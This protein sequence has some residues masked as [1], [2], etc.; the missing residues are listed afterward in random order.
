[1][2]RLGA[3]YRSFR[4]SPNLSLRCSHRSGVLDELAGSPLAEKLRSAAEVPVASA[5][6]GWFALLLG[7]TLLCRANLFVTTG[8]FAR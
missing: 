2:R 4:I 1:V 3:G 7:G 8:A 6:T 5:V